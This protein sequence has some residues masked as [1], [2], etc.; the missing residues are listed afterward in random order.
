MDRYGRRAC[1]VNGAPGMFHRW[2]DRAGV[3]GASMM[4]G[5]H[6]GGQLWEVFGLVELHDGNMIEAMPEDITFVD[7]PGAWDCSDI[8]D[9]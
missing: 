1:R 3:V 7:E 8:E 2:I 5:G 6:R 9:G 4:I